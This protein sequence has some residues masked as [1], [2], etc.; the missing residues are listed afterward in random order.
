MNNRIKA[1]FFDLGETLMEL[2]SFSLCMYDSLKRH[3]LQSLTIDLN[4]LASMWGD[5]ALRLFVDYRKRNFIETREIHFL[6][7]KKILKISKINITD[8]LAHIIVEDVWQNFVKN[9]KLYPDV[10]PVLNQLKQSGYTLGLITD[11]DL[12]IANGIIK[13]HNLTIFFDVK[14]ISG[15]VRMYKPDPLLFEKAINL[16]KC[17]PGEGIYVGDSEIDVKGAA[18]VGLK[19]VIVNRNEI[20]DS[21]FGIKPDFRVIT[22]ILKSG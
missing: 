16:V 6:G 8:K 15:E 10:M 5:E 11:S 4:E 17:T 21:E 12:D 3:L 13:K 20:F 2:S 22:I 19:T 14:V 1:I 9:N 18:E 7:L